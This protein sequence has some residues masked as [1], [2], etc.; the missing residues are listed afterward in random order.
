MKNISIGLLVLAFL[1]G[2]VQPTAA[3]A[4][5]GGDDY[6]IEYRSGDDRF[7]YR[8]GSDHDDD[9]DKDEDVD[10]NEDDSDDDNNDDD[11]NSNDDDS[12]E[13]L[14]VE[15]DV[16]TDMTIVKVELE[17]GKKTVFRTNADTREEVIDVVADE[18]NL[19]EDEVDDVLD[20]EIENRASRAKERAK[21][22]GTN[23][24]S[25]DVCDDSSS[26][27]TLEVEADVFTD[28]TIVKVEKGST[29]TVYESDATTSAAIVDEVADK[30]NLDEDDVEDVID[31]E[32]EDRASRTSDFSVSS[33][34]D[35]DCD[36]DN[37]SNSNNNSSNGN[38]DA[39]LRARIAQ[40]QDLI[41][42]LI[43]LLNLRLGSGN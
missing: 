41:Q 8:S 23:N 2:A 21:I 40:L 10:E 15:A 9:D 11:D 24:S 28:T 20:F 4:K 16:F 6:R 38:K 39:E 27:S 17:N 37:S 5:K 13:S 3:Y 26:T 25:V 18:F 1:V 42:N 7:E 33:S 31:F 22:T 32:V 43:R 34:N 36:D 29:K 12:N 19:T 30:F 35:D 14:E